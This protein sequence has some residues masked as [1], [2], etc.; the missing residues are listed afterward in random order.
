MHG[1]GKSYLRAYF[2]NVVATYPGIPSLAEMR[3]HIDKWLSEVR[4]RRRKMGKL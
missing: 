1:I 4:E 2:G 3:L